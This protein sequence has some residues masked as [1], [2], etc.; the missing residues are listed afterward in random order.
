[1]LLCSVLNAIAFGLIYG[2]TEV[3]VLVYTSFG[4]S[5]QASL[6]LYL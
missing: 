3:L 2:L 6:V 4:F 1:V 5:A